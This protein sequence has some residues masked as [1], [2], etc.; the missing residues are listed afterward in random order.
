VAAWNHHQAHL[1]LKSDDPPA[2]IHPTRNAGLANLLLALSGVLDPSV[3]RHRHPTVLPSDLRPGAR[4]AR[5]RRNRRGERGRTGVWQGG[6][7][8]QGMVEATETLLCEEPRGAKG[9]YNCTAA[10]SF[11]AARW[12]LYARLSMRNSF[13]SPSI[14]APTPGRASTP[15]CEVPEQQDHP[16]TTEFT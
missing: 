12:R 8:W 2:G 10:N 15:V 11:A 14:R 4:Y 1:L 16:F 7:S 5:P 13:V 9:R 3:D 6:P